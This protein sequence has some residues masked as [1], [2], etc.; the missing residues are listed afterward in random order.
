VRLDQFAQCGAAR[1][2]FI[3]DGVEA[4]ALDCRL[5]SGNWPY[6]AV[7]AQIGERIYLG[8]GIPGAFQPA[9]C[10]RRCSVWRG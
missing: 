1:P 8:D 4:L 3:L 5:R 6:Q 10:P 7:V 2:T 9:A